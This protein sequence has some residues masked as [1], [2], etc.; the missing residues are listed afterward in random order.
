MK[1]QASFCISIDCE[2]AWGVRDQISY[3][4]IEKTLELDENIC[5]NLLTIFNDF[6]I[7]ATWAI[8]A[9]ML[10]KNNPMIKNYDSKR[11]GWL[12]QK[13]ISSVFK[14]EFVPICRVI[15]SFGNYRTLFY[16]L[17]NKIN[18]EEK[19]QKPNLLL[20]DNEKIN[21]NAL[22]S[23][24]KPYLNIIQNTSSFYKLQYLIVN[25]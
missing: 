2:L 8:V 13:S 5:F 19:Y 12:K 11:D 18:S 4:F 7:N 15:G 16:Y 10:D 6:D 9:G 25:S 14:N 21:N 23:Y 20:K 24:F 3:K 22:Y 17:M 1:D